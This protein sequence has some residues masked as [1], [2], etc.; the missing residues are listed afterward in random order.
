MRN[1][2]EKFFKGLMI[3]ASCI[4]ITVLSFI[5]YVIIRKGLPSLSWDMISKI[6]SGGFYLG[7]EGGIL[8]A[9]LG[10]L[11]L[12]TG[13]VLLS[14]SIS[15][16]VVL[17]INF[18]LQKNSKFSNIVRFAFDILFGIPSIVYGAFGFMLMIFL[19]LHASLIG[20][21]LAVSLL[22][23][24]IMVRSIDEVAAYVP[25]DL[26][27]ATQSL[28]TT[29]YETLKIIVRQI[30]PGITTAILLATGRGIGDAAAVLFTAGY[31]DSITVSPGQPVATLPLAIFFQ[32]SSPIEEVQ[33]RAY[34]AA[35]ILTIL[36]LI[37]SFSARYFSGKLSKSKL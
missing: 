19:G 35:L 1:L 32:L 22:I 27:E 15:L 20:G 37:L 26:I 17:Y 14:F 6:P 16:P 11:F 8:N 25:R 2:E 10:S 3:S 28:G 34:A 36:I 18:I 5:L 21:I 31:T 4:I 13:S 7:K 24:P 33:N 12:I 29:R 9:I 23:I 30:M